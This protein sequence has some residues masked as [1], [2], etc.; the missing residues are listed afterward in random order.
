M[1]YRHDIKLE[2][3]FTRMIKAILGNYFIGQDP[4]HDR[5]QGTDFEVFTVHPFTVGVRLRRFHYFKRYGDQFTVR[6][7]RPSGVPTEI[8]KIRAGLVD[9]ILYGFVDETEQN[10][11]SYFIGDLQVFRE[12]DPRPLCV[13]PNNPPDSELAAFRIKDL[14]P[15]FVLHEWQTAEV[16]YA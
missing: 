9:Y 13:L 16:M 3:K 14:P 15:G 8:D 11:V 5:K 4:I 1:G 12:C 10:I 6:W 7:S 2:H